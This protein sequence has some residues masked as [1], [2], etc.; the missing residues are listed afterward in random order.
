MELLAV[1]LLEDLV[2]L[3]KLQWR[4][5]VGAVL[6]YY[7]SFGVAAV[8]FLVSIYLTLPILRDAGMPGGSNIPYN[9]SIGGNV[10]WSFSLHWTLPLLGA[11]LASFGIALSKRIEF[12]LL[13]VGHDAVLSSAEGL[14][15]DIDLRPR[16]RRRLE[17][18]AQATGMALRQLALFGLQALKILFT[19][20]LLLLLE[21]I[22]LAVTAI[23]AVVLSFVFR[24]AIWPKKNAAESQTNMRIT[25]NHRLSLS[26]S[27]RVF[28]SLM[29]LTA[30]L[31]LAGSRLTELFSFDL[32][33]FLFLCMLVSVLGNALGSLFQSV[34]RLTRRS[35]L[36]QQALLALCGE[37]SEKV[38]SLLMGEQPSDAQDI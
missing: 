16:E 9:I 36:Q 8:V 20:A 12:R 28:S 30:L 3:L 31:V 21:P 35:T 26:D 6:Y 17:Q 32:A 38:Y 34:L 4:K 24:G 22:I 19:A 18:I 1:R 11:S 10:H 5:V 15:F 37:E 13:Q 33:D 29:P 7:L 27:Q 14:L 2:N 23:V 25:I